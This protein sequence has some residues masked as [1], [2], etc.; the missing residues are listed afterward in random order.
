MV[1]IGKQAGQLPSIFRKSPGYNVGFEWT[2]VIAST[3]YIRFYPCAME[4]AG[5]ITYFLSTKILESTPWYKAS[6]HVP[7]Q[8]GAALMIDLDFDIEFR[9]TA[10]VKGTALINASMGL[11]DELIQHQYITINIYHVRAAAETLLGTAS[12]V[13]RDWG[14]GLPHYLRET[15]SVTLTEKQFAAG[16]KLRFNYQIWAHDDAGGSGH[17]RGY[18]DPAQ[19]V[20][21]YTDGDGLPVPIDITFDCP[22]KID[23]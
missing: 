16:D 13:D 14:G 7:V 8:A 1:E 12:T 4:L 2:D 6:A 5:G 21:T 15:L 10:T 17:V 19:R 23:I 20:T 18:F 3:G 11:T 9:T 22:F